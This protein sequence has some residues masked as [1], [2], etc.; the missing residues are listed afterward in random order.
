MLRRG[1]V[2]YDQTD[3]AQEQGSGVQITI[4]RNRRCRSCLSTRANRSVSSLSSTSSASSCA[5]ASSV[6]ANATSVA[7]PRSAGTRW[8][9]CARAVLAYRASTLSRP[10]GIFDRSRSSTPSSRASLSRCKASTHPAAVGWVGP[11]RSR[12]SGERRLPAGTTNSCLSRS[13]C[14]AEGRPAN[15]RYR[16]TL[17]RSRMRVISLA[18]TD[19]PAVTPGVR[20]AR[21]WPDRTGRS[22]VRHSARH[23]CTT[24]AQEATRRRH[25]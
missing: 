3:I 11:R 15:L 18:R 17:A 4:V 5:L 16:R 22:A 10:A 14:S 25:H 19:T 8:I 23:V 6:Q 21:R 13:R 9:P 2:K 20:P 7:I 12:S 1:P 24:S